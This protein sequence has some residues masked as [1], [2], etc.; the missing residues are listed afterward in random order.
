M[1]LPGYDAWKTTPPEFDEVALSCDACGCV[2]EDEDSRD[3]DECDQC[4][5]GILTYD[6]PSE[7]CRCIDTC[8]C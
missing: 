4:G 5:E 8:Y 6:V 2:C 7:P 1:D 3:G